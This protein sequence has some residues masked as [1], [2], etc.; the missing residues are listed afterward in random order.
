MRVIGISFP[1]P[2]ARVTPNNV[3]PLS[4]QDNDEGDTIGYPEYLVSPFL[5]FKPELLPIISLEYQIK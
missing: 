3:I 1:Y 2:K 4:N 5:V